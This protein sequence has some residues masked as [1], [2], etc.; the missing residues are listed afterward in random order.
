MKEREEIRGTYCCQYNFF[1]LK[2]YSIP[3]RGELTTRPVYPFALFGKCFSDIL[4]V[5]KLRRSFLLRFIV[6][7]VA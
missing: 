4:R 1:P 3:E 7:N 6:E 2:E 5:C